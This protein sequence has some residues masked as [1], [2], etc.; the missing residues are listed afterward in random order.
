MPLISAQ[1]IVV[2]RDSAGNAADA[3]QRLKAALASYPDCRI[4]SI[5]ARTV[6]IGM[7][8]LVAVIETV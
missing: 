3:S 4:V 5:A 8:E 7:L 2:A 6:G 1:D